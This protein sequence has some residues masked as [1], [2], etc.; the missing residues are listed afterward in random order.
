MAAKQDAQE[1]IALCLALLEM[2][3]SMVAFLKQCRVFDKLL[4]EFLTI[5]SQIDILQSNLIE[6]LVEK[7]DVCL[8]VLVWQF[9]VFDLCEHLEQNIG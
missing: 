6:S 7:I 2:I 5:D 8:H 9:K 1:T 3:E 4:L